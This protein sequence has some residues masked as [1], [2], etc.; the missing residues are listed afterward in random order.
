MANNNNREVTPFMSPDTIRAFSGF[1]KKFSDQH[2]KRYQGYEDIDG[3]KYVGTVENFGDEILIEARKLLMDKPSLKQ[4][5][6]IN[7]LSRYFDIAFSDLTDT[8]TQQNMMV[9]LL[10]ENSLKSY[11]SYS[12][13]F[14][15][16]IKNVVIR[17]KSWGSKTSNDKSEVM[18]DVFYTTSNPPELI[19]SDNNGNVIDTITLTLSVE[20][21]TIT[22]YMAHYDTIT[23]DMFPKLTPVDNKYTFEIPVTNKMVGLPFIWFTVDL[24]QTYPDIGITYSPPD[25]YPM[26]SVGT[27]GHGITHLY[28]YTTIDMLPSGLPFEWYIKA[29]P[30]EGLYEPGRTALNTSIE[31]SYIEFVKAENPSMT[32]THIVP[33]RYDNDVCK[34][35]ISNKGWTIYTDKPDDPGYDG[36]TLN[37][38][39]YAWIPMSTFLH[40]AS[41]DSSLI[42]AFDVSFKEEYIAYDG[43]RANTMSGIHVDTGTDYTTHSVVKDY[44][45][46]H[47]LGQFDGLPDYFR[48]LLDRKLHR[49]HVELYSIRDRLGRINTKVYEKQTAGLI[50]DSGIPQTELHKITDDMPVSIY[51]AGNRTFKTHTDKVISINNSLSE[52][53]YE[54]PYTFNNSTVLEHSKCPKFVYHGNRSFS[55]GLMELDPDIER[56]RVYIISN[57]PIEYTNKSDQYDIKRAFARICDIP[58]DYGQLIHVPNIAPTIL[59]DQKYVHSDAS[60][61]NDDIERLWNGLIPKFAYASTTSLKGTKN[62]WILPAGYKINSML[63][64]PKVKSDHSKWTNI[65]KTIDFSDL[66]ITIANGGSGYKENDTF[67]F[68]IGGIPIDG[69]VFSIVENGVV[70]II[71]IDSNI[72]TIHP[73]NLD[74]RESIITVKNRKS[75]NGTGLQLKIT[76]P[77]DVWYNLEPAQSDELIDDIYA[78][79]FDE[80]G[81]IWLYEYTEKHTWEKHVQV[82]GT[83]IIENPYDTDDIDKTKRKLSDVMLFNW[84]NSENVMLQ[85]VIDNPYDYRYIEQFKVSF[86]GEYKAELDASAFIC[87]KNIQ[88]GYYVMQ[89]SDDVTSGECTVISSCLPISESGIANE[90]LLPRFHEL[91]TSTYFNITNKFLVSSEES[92]QPNLY[93]F[94]PNRDFYYE[95]NNDIHHEKNSRIA[96]SKHPITFNDVLYVDDNQSTLW[97]DNKGMVRSNIYQYDVYKP[98]NAYTS[99][100]NNIYRMDKI[101]IIGLIEKYCSGDISN[102]MKMGLEELQ[103]YAMMNVYTMLSDPFYHK[104][105]ISLIRHLHEQVI[106]NVTMGEGE[107]PTGSYMCLTSDEVDVSVKVDNTRAHAVP[108]YVF[109]MEYDNDYI[110]AAYRIY[111]EDD[112]D[113]TD[114]SLIICSNGLKFV[115][116]NNRWVSINNYS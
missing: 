15:D 45:V 69:H 105:M 113:I 60:F 85:D 48:Y 88:G 44:G 74:G 102:L 75:E 51:Y 107:Q 115:F 2:T 61:K 11:Y 40:N 68:M 98:T 83:P 14:T 24:L 63:S 4:M 78:F 80:F 106:V 99:L 53:T 42:E 26:L 101:S 97:I 76:V 81:F 33:V 58:T 23:K 86:P 62:L 54:D 30:K 111:D 72:D 8:Y 6:T 20:D 36:T 18:K 9:A 10:K 21:W 34:I 77:E 57:D 29:Y 13:R 35:S 19:I 109:E 104:T 93:L 65:N 84:L 16:C 89:E 59:F 49:S 108:M 116:R 55:L 50:L 71:S 82:T 73:A 39:P 28:P 5:F 3:S 64:Y 87:Y 103:A 114:L 7:N 32:P 92:S 46:I 66:E 56:G 79:Q 100:F 12:I 27:D 90:L 91:N 1:L 95:I 112:N 41:D 94:A 110:P 52:I 37:N 96:S 38:L 31:V 22:T 70:F 47:D 17:S 43:N 25:M 67:Y